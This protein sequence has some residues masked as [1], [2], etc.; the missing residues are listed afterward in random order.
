MKLLL[1]S[2]LIVRSLVVIIITSVCTTI[3]GIYLISEGIVREAQ[4]RVSLDLNSA[5]QVFKQNIKGIENII[6]YTAMREF[7]VKQALQELNR[8]QL[9]KSLH[10]AMEKSNIDF[11]TITN[12][13]GL[14][15]LR[16]TNPDVYGDTQENDEIIKKVLDDRK[17]YSGAQILSKEK[18]AQESDELANRAYIRLIHT[19]KGKNNSEYVNTS[20]MV[21]KSAVP[22]FDSGNTLIGV[23]YGGILLNRKYDIVDTIKN[24]VYKNITYKNKDIGTATIF[25]NDIRIAT[26][27]LLKNGERAIGTRVSEG[28][29][30]KV[31]KEGCIWTSRAFVVNTWYLSAYQPIR[32]IQGKIIGILYVGMLEKKYEDLKKIA[33]FF[34]FCATVIGFFIALIISYILSHLLVLPI[35]QLEQGMNEIANGNFNYN[36]EIHSNDEIGSL[37]QSFNKVRYQLKESYMKLQGKIKTSNEN[38]KKAYN[39]L[40][41]QQEKLVQAERLASMGQLSAGVAHELNNPLGTIILYA[42]ILKDKFTND[43]S[44]A[45]IE[46]I[47]KEAMRCKDI[48]RDLLN[49]SRQSKIV[50]SST[51]ISSLIEDVVKIVKSQAEENNITINTDVPQNFPDIMIDEAQIKQMLIN[52]IENS[53]DA[54]VNNGTIRIKI[55]LIDAAKTIKIEIIDTGC[56][57]PPI[58][59]SKVFNPF[60]TTKEMGKGTG[61]GLAIAYGI[62]KMHCGDI[63]VD[64]QEGKE[65]IFTISLPIKQEA[66]NDE[67]IL[68]KHTDIRYKSF[69]NLVK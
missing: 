69:N 61:L 15:V 39:G 67:N 68:T 1:R 25:Q 33:F 56:G 22:V 36:V 48:I 42:H 65:T 16:A 57:I 3:I 63:T 52:L 43:P 14:V 37:V 6:T 46:M 47:V 55:S 49:F 66:K 4:E 58:N 31:L 54:I 28:V 32:N 29:Y 23:L 2:K 21:L 27:V 24:I 59:L 17:T 34:F 8:A 50:T 53:I 45:D 5:N 35:K 10:Y 9:L 62:V 19:Q 38:L 12:R 60:F 26:N 44:K 41:I 20:G 11:L 18:L 51:K 30:D 7:A 64:S 40:F 13:K